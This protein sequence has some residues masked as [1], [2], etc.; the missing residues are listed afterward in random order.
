MDTHNDPQ[1]IHTVIESLVT[2]TAQRD[3]YALEESL[4][5]TIRHLLPGFSEVLS[6]PDHYNAEAPHRRSIPSSDEELPEAVRQG[7][8]QVIQGDDLVHVASD[9]Q[10]YLLVRLQKT[11]H[12]GN[13]VLIVA[14]Q[15]AE[16]QAS[17][18]IEAM[19]MLY[20][21]FV[22]LLS[23][24]EHDTLT[25]L[26]N[27]RKLE[28]TLNALCSGTVADRPDQNTRSY[29]RILDLDHFKR[30][31]DNFG[32]LIGDE[33]L[34]TFADIL[35][36]TLRTGDMIFRY[37]GEEFMVLLH[38]VTEPCALEVLDRA[39]QAVAEHDFPQVGRVTVSMG[40]TDINPGDM[41]T[42]VIEEADRALYFAKENGRNQVRHFAALLQEGLV[43][44]PR[45]SG[46]I[47]L[48]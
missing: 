23:D 33:V 38:D 27:R 4:I 24:N 10:T 29:L 45:D 25:G 5:S 30:I 18:L 37:G 46:S 44:Q 21:N 2:L 3:Q 28:A 40:F 15:Q 6:I 9:D 1:T 8:A 42:Q 11:I 13:R 20:R 41:P 26:Y 47:E 7:L 48:F 35:R 12:D 43:E 16:S 17:F 36:R 32:H 14:T 34:L 19:A 31:N 39:R 22:D